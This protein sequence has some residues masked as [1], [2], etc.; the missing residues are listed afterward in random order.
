MRIFAADHVEQHGGA[1]DRS[2]PRPAVL[3][4]EML[5]AEEIVIVALED[6]FLAVEEDEID[7]DVESSCPSCGGPTP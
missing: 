6:V 7:A 5:R 1:I 2:L 4:A 3:S